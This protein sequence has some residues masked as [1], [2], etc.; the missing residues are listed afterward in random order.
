MNPSNKRRLMRILVASSAHL[1]AS[2]WMIASMACEPAPASEPP[3]GAAAKRSPVV[4]DD[5][6]RARVRFELGRWDREPARIIRPEGV[7]IQLED[8]FG[9][10][11]ISGT[12]MKNDES[13]VP[14]SPWIATDT[15]GR[16]EVKVM[17]TDATGATAGG[18]FDLELRDDWHWNVMLTQYPHDPQIGCMGCFGS[19]RFTTS[20][21]QDWSMWAV[22]GGNSISNPVVY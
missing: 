10:R 19:H 18:A 11:S 7:V 2:V 21:A 20:V 15:K 4:A 9:W 13:G 16:L 6:S 1:L 14:V 12:D 17:V 22:W 5:D 8:S 3:T